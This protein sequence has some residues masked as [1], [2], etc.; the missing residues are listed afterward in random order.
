[1]PFRRNISLHYYLP[2]TITPVSKALI[3]ATWHICLSSSTDYPVMQ[4]RFAANF[5]FYFIFLLLHFEPLKH[6][7]NDCGIHY[8]NSFFLPNSQS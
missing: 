3:I 1:M 8:S 6:S 2:I 7:A 4:L 5:Q